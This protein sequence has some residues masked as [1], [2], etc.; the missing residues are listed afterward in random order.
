MIA[1]ILSVAALLTGA[2]AF[3]APSSFTGSRVAKSVA[4]SSKVAMMSEK[5][6]SIPFMPKPEK[7]DGT[8]PGDVGFDPLGF[9]NF[10]SLDFL[11]EAEI[12]HGRICMLAVAG[13]IVVDL[14]L[15]L[16]GDVHLVDSLTAHDNAVRFGAMSQILLWVSMFEAV[17]SVA[18]FQM[19]N[20]SGRKPGEFGFDPLKFASDPSKRAKLALNEIKN[21][22]LAMLA[23]SGIVTQAALGHSFPYI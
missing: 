23:F 22:R 15:H 14:G 17:S 16:P 9:S 13:W 1:K 20:G 5:S 11:S 10:I 19:L 18:V 12:K 7:L 3:T 4:S 2:S 8:L 21:G 6:K